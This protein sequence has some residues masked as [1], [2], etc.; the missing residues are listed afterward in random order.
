MV[1]WFMSAPGVGLQAGLALVFQLVGVALVIL[2][3]RDARRR[4]DRLNRQ[5]IDIDNDT[6][7]AI[8]ASSKET[9]DADGNVRPNADFAT[10]FSAPFLTVQEVV[11]GLH[12]KSAAL[13]EQHD[14]HRGPA[15]WVGPTVLL[16][17]ILFSFTATISAL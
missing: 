4:L 1:N 8:E 13:A 3:V 9:F 10:L 11:N 5:F 12:R 7:Q 6:M 16:L 17:G 14:D 15:A 2:D